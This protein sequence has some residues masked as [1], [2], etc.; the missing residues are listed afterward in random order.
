MLFTLASPLAAEGKALEEASDDQERH[1]QLADVESNLVKEAADRFFEALRSEDKTAL[2]AVMVPE[3]VIFVHNRMDPAN[4]RVDVVP[5][6]EHLER[7]ARGTRAV[8]EVMTYET[9][10]VDGDMAH[11][12]GPYRFAVEGQTTHCGINSISL[13]RTDRS[14]YGEWKVANTSFTMVPPVQ[15][16][17]IGAPE[18]AQ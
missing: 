8:D 9:V 15:C 5:V 17:A 14:V 12:W 1:I 16:A 10:L 18:F 7:W 2:A 3:A 4:P 11:V 6:G 13:I